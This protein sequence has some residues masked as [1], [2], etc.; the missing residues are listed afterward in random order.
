[1]TDQLWTSGDDRLI[2]VSELR[3]AVDLIDGYSP[4][5]SHQIEQKPKMLEMC[6]SFPDV[7]HRHCL[8][9]HLTAS[10]L[11]VNESRDQVLLHHHAKLNRWLQFGGH[12]DGDGNLV[13]VAWREAVEES[14]IADLLI[15]PN[16]IDLDIH[17]IPA[18]GKTPEHLHL[19]VRF[20]A[21]ARAN[22][23]PVVSD[24]SNALLWYRVADVGC[25]D[26]DESVIRLIELCR[27]EDATVRFEAPASKG[28]GS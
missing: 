14:G 3:F 27:D 23:V 20:V 16:I 2:E 12:C 7:L 11:V 22:S 10:A 9:A 15:D 5:D 25:I 19:D 24:E 4:Q 21:F 26:T 13:H 1:M 18:R 17:T 6:H 28:D 8:T